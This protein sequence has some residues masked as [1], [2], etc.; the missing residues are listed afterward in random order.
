MRTE[1]ERPAAG[2]REGPYAPQHVLTRDR[3]LCLPTGRF[4]RSQPG[5]GSLCSRPLPGTERNEPPLKDSSGR[6]NPR[7]PLCG[8]H[9]ALSMG[10]ACKPSR[11]EHPARCGA[12]A[13][14]DDGT[15]THDLLHGKSERPFAAVRARSLKPA[16][17]RGFHASERTRPNPSERRTLPSLPRSQAPNPDSASGLAALGQTGA[18]MPGSPRAAP[19]S[20]R[21]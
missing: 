15:R 6:T 2:R 7:S 8:F 4:D 1:G 12:F 18:A 21:P 13:K 17:C 14:A 19:A 10:R 16:V 5:G 9:R 3:G 11:T 20:A